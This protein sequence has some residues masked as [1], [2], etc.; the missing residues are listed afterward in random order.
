MHLGQH[1]RGNIL[2]VAPSF[3][4]RL[5]RVRDEL[6]NV[7][8]YRSLPHV[9]AVV[10][11]W[12]RNCNTERPHSRLRLYEP[13]HLRPARRPAC[14]AAPSAPLRGP[15]SPPPNRPPVRGDSSCRRGRSWQLPSLGLCGI[16][17]IRRAGVD[18]AV[19]DDDGRMSKLIQL[20]K[21]DSV[22][23]FPFRICVSQEGY[24]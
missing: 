11:A 7:T 9:R 17:M 14:S 16:G 10:E 5:G 8:L 15:R 12:R 13:L 24:I 23:A 20:P 22:G 2:D 4:L 18:V 6:L 3:V 19:F 1:A 21:W